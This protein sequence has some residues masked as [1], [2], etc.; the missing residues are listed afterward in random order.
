MDGNRMYDFRIAKN[1][2]QLRDAYQLRYQVYCKEEKLFPR[3]RFSKTIFVDEFDT[4]FFNNYVLN[5]YYDNEIVATIRMVK[6]SLDRSPIDKYYDCSFYRDMWGKEY[7]NVLFG[8][9]SMVA[10]RKDHRRKIRLFENLMYL[11]AQQCIDSG[12]TNVII[13]PRYET[14]KIYRKLG[15]HQID[16]PFFSDDVNDTLIPMGITSEDFYKSVTWNEHFRFGPEP[17]TGSTTSV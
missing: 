3:Y 2:E 15:F 13:C 14:F 4:L 8:S 5:A 11:T 7:Q 12:V 17:H 16:R 6:D 10:I 1:T 9:A